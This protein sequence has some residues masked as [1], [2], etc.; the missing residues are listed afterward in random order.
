M[1][2]RE[3]YLQKSNQQPRERETVFFSDFGL[4]RVECAEARDG[5]SLEKTSVC[6]MVFGD[7]SGFRGEWVGERRSSSPC[8]TLWVSVCAC[9]CV[10]SQVVINAYGPWVAC[11]ELV[12]VTRRLVDAVK[13]TGVSRM[14]PVPCDQTRQGVS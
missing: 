12:A 1:I 5:G 14:V 9:V 13:E 7:A 2:F 8:A 6:V 4:L 10:A 3:L 11:E